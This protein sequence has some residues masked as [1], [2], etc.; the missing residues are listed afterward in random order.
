MDFLLYKSACDNG[1][2]FLA[3][4]RC[5][6]KHRWTDGLC[7]ERRR[8]YLSKK[9]VYAP[10]VSTHTPSLARFSRVAAELEQITS[11][12]R[13]IASF[14]KS[15]LVL[16]P[17]LNFRELGCLFG[18]PAQVLPLPCSEH[19]PVTRQLLEHSKSFH[20]LTHLSDGWGL[21]KDP[22]KCLTSRNNRT[23]FGGVRK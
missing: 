18:P 16:G 6:F 12:Y 14:P 1:H 9:T 19:V 17:G 2:S 11:E 22:Q 15:S 3:I 8:P 10:A 7:V 23:A 20:L 5:Y 13:T 21:S 4:R